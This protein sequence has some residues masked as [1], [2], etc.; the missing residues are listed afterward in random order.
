[1]SF[2]TW[3]AKII[4][5][6]I[7]GVHDISRLISFSIVWT[8]FWVSMFVWF[9]TIR[10]FPFQNRDTHC[11]KNIKALTGIR[12]ATFFH[13]LR[14]GKTL[15]TEIY[16]IWKLQLHRKLHFKCPVT[17]PLR[18]RD[19]I[20]IE[21]ETIGRVKIGPFSFL[22]FLLNV[23]YLESFKM[24][25]KAIFTLRFEVSVADIHCKELPMYTSNVCLQ[26]MHSIG[27]QWPL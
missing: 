1:M 25:S 10:I 6:S 13:C 7:F 27:I 19:K 26:Q 5:H 2:Q 24:T 15:H 12:K 4:L 8:L 11:N 14:E 22:F 3:S 16:P 18:Q 17:T 23:Y 21:M 20:C 9:K